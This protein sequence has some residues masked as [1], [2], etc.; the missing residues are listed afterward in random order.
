MNNVLDN[1]IG[2]RLKALRTMYKLS[3]REVAKRS[4][5]T[6]STISLIEQGRVSPSVDSIKK[7]SNSFSLSLVEFLTMNVEEDG[8]IFFAKEDLLS[9]FEK[10]AHLKLVGANRK[11]RKLRFLHE[12]Y[13]QGASSGEHMLSCDSEEAGIIIKGQIELTVG[14]ASRVLGEGDSYY[15]NNNIP[16]RFKNVGKGDAIIISAETPPSF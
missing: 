14:Q 10:G 13:E 8:D 9:F 4:G 2:T 12:R 15:I 6:N 11:D 16:H 3:Q 1:E 7:I 5:V